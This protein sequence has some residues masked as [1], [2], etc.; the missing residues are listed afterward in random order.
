MGRVGS[1]LAVREE[2]LGCEISRRSRAEGHPGTAA[3][4]ESQ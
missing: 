3:L 2:I 4:N 1:L